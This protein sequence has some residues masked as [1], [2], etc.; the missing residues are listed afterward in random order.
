VHRNRTSVFDKGLGCPG[1]FLARLWVPTCIVRARRRVKAAAPALVPRGG[2]RDAGARTEEARVGRAAAG[3]EDARDAGTT[4]I[5]ACRGGRERKS[6]C[7]KSRI[8]LE[9]RRI[10]KGKFGILCTPVH[11]KRARVRVPLPPDRRPIKKAREQSLG[12]N[13]FAER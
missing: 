9:K 3:F 13:T 5:D 10:R 2:R 11:E 6:A 1:Q 12:N 8:R 4:T 7:M